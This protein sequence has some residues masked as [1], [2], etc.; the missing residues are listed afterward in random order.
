MQKSLHGSR[1]APATCTTEAATPP[2]SKDPSAVKR[3]GALRNTGTGLW[4][5]RGF[6][7]LDTVSSGPCVLSSDPLVVT[8]DLLMRVL[9]FEHP[10]KLGH[11]GVHAGIERVI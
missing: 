3:S 8:C 6:S 7:C 2:P 4:N 1:R 5:M 10:G 9:T 11:A